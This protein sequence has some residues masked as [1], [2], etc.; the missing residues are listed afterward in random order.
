M[1]V[2]AVLQCLRALALAARPWRM[3]VYTVQ[4]GPVLGMQARQARICRNAC[5]DHNQQCSKLLMP[6]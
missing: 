1:F 6:A 2:L 3:A 4:D 5:P